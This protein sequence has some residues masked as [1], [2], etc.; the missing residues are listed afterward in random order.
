MTPYQQFI[1][2]SRYCRF[3][4]DKGRRE[5]WPEPVDRWL[6]F[7]DDYLQENGTEQFYKNS[8]LQHRAELREAMVNLEVMPSMRSLMT[9]GPALAR[10][11]VA[12]YNCAYVAVDEPRVFAEILYV[13]MCG[14]G[15]GFTV[16]R[17]AV[18][19]LPEV[20]EVMCDVDSTIVVRD[21]KK[22]W[23]GALK[24]LI[25][26]LYE[27]QVPKLDYSKI[28]PA[29]TLLKTFGGRAS[30][31]EPFRTLCEF[32]IALFR[33]A[34]GRK[35]TSIEVHDLVCKIGEVVVVGGVRRAALI[36]LSDITDEWMRKA[37]SGAWW[38]KDGQRAMANNSA[39]YNRKPSMDLFFDEWQ[40]LY[41]SKS[42]ERGIFSR[43]A[44][45]TKFKEIDRRWIEG[46]LYG[47]NP[48]GEI[49]LR[50]KQFCNLSEAVARPDDT[51]TSLR[52]K[53]RLATLIGT[54]QALLTNFSFL[55]KQWQVNCE[56]ERL[57]GVSITGIWDNP[58]L[59]GDEGWSEMI[60]FLEGVRNEVRHLNENWSNGLGVNPSA[61][62]TTVKPSGTVSQLVDSASGIHP[63]YASLY[64]R[65]VRQDKKDPLS[66]VLID[67]G[68]PYEEDFYNPQAWVFSFPTKAP[69]GAVVQ[70]EVDSKQHLE[71]WQ[72]YR[73]HWTDHNPSVTI[74]VEDDQ[75]MSVGSW[76]YDNF[77]QVGGL[78][79]LPEDGGSYRQAPY[80]RVNLA[81]YQ[82]LVDQSPAVLDLSALADLERDDYTTGSRD[83]ACSAGQ[84]AI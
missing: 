51:A 56:E 18:S 74:T 4:H 3:D 9:A 5:V 21:S 65:R 55:G 78:S 61:A 67:Q 1:A 76:V 10:D 68:V 81:K 8:W 57:L 41:Q 59:R 42:G 24:Q 28:R 43:V 63:R 69:D 33:K 22:G 32:T 49:L 20:A 54:V 2:T 66:Q 15:V 30:G 83:L 13:L 19:K 31:P 25:A 35:L 58:L 37:K 53:L 80:E 72:A 11:H 70:N 27:G 26:M 39:A 45:R 6:G 84:C 40:S 16:E 82:E 60:Q 23:A 50:P 47:T 48:C 17:D 38:E 73:N 12:G 52:K 36:S 44:A 29:G 77:D 71:L 79:F 46:V 14:T 62:I 64:I 7:F 34:A 75:W